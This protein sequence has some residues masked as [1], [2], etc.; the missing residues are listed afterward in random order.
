MKTQFECDNCGNKQSIGGNILQV[1]NF[2]T[3]NKWWINGKTTYCP[4]CNVVINKH[5]LKSTEQLNN[6]KKDNNSKKEDNHTFNNELPNNKKPNSNNNK[7]SNSESYNNRNNSQN[8]ISKTTGSGKRKLEVFSD[9]SCVGGNPGD[10]GWAWVSK[11]GSDSDMDVIYPSTNQRMEIKAAAEALKSNADPI[12][13]Y[14]DSRY[15]VDCINKFWYKGW[16]KRG[17][18]TANGDEVKNKELWLELIAQLDHHPN[19]TV[20]WV[21]GHANNEYNNKADE[22]ARMA[23]FN[24]K[25]K[26]E[27]R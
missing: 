10:G 23:A 8:K 20:E 9:G 26:R 17:W 22:L 27:G 2:M 18:K 1:F 5:N 16:I 4:T 19:L 15:V 13:L 25:N 21:K 7:K 11:K 3:D 14:T 6:N 24:G 12:I